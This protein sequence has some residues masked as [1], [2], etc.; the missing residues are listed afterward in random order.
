MIVT[1]AFVFQK[2]DSWLWISTFKYCT[3]NLYY[4]FL[5]EIWQPRATKTQLSRAEA[6]IIEIKQ[7]TIM[8]HFQTIYNRFLIHVVLNDRDGSFQK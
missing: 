6:L 7:S 4:L 3:M 2:Y 1:V 8:E 5:S